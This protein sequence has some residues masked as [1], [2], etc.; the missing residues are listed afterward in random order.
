M[1]LILSKEEYKL[2]FNQAGFEVKH[3]IEYDKL[4]S[5]AD[6]EKG[7]RN[8]ICQFFASDLLGFPD[9]HNR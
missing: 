3:I 7:L 6:G 9:E 5:L 2:L 1:I 4:I 8:W